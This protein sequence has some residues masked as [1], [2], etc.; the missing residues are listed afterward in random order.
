MKIVYLIGPRLVERLCILAS[1]M[2]LDLWIKDYLIWK[3]DIIISS[4]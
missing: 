4:A 2:D 1:Q 3:L